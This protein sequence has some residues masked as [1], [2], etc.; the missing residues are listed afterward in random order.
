MSYTFQVHQKEN[1]K[2]TRFISYL[3][4]TDHNRLSL[5]LSAVNRSLG[6]KLRLTYIK[7]HYA[8]RKCSVGIM[9][10]ILFS[11]IFNP[12]VLI[13]NQIENRS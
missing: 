4:K 7:I 11:F 10:A 6:F 3:S 8:E 13:V 12:Y 1:L 5:S 2:K 9:C